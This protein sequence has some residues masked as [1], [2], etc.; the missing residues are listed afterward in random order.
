VIPVL[1]PDE[2]RAVDAAAPEPVE[3]LVDRAGA[4]VARSALDLLGG[5]YG[6]RVVVV[7][8]KGSNGADGRVA[9]DR[10]R[11]RGVRVEVL[12]AAE[13]PEVLPPADLVVDAAYGTG[14][15]GTWD[16]PSPG[17]APV[18]AVDVPSGVDALTGE[19]G[20]STMAAVR[21]VTFQALKPG[22]LLGRGAE[23]SGAVEVHDIGLDV[24]GA[25]A[26]VVE[27]HDVVLPVRRRDTHKWRS[28]VW[29]I[30]GSPG[31]TGAAR[32]A[33]RAA[34]RI[35]AGYV[36]L[37]TPGGDPDAPLEAVGT[38]LPTAGWALDDLDRFRALVVGPGLGR[39]SDE[40]VRRLVATSP[41]PVVVDGDGLTA[42]AGR[43]DVAPS[44]V[45]TPHDGEYERLVGHA[46]GGDRLAAARRLAD[47]AGC[48]TLLKG[49]TTVVAE[50][51]GRVLVAAAGGP[52]L[53]TAGT[54]DVLAGMVAG[55]V[56]QG[57]PPFEAAAWGAHLHGRAAGLGP[58]RGLV[59]GD[60]PDLLPAAVADLEA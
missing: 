30:A 58:G 21:T 42:L 55:L 25:A 53:A 54:G 60:L 51:G 41:V 50:P 5:A 48:V 39:S 33:T 35:G 28:A 27:D 22:H 3:V 24:S 32:L 20:D 52:G 46:P 29:V 37:S 16:A 47:A 19:A 15:H 7:A 36:R 49:S 43:L 57:V 13:A 38:T 23:L 14:F 59:A 10:L 1:T 18:L 8:G 34:Q 6:R 44:A 31:M 45:L 56:A 4:A 17:G 11:R 2:V 26:H 9:A 12:D 40:D